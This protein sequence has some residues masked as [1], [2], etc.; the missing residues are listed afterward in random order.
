MLANDE[1]GAPFERDAMPRENKVGTD[2]IVVGA[3]ERLVFGDTPLQFGIRGGRCGGG[4]GG[5]TSRRQEGVLLDD[6]IC[7]ATEPLG[8]V[9][10]CICGWIADMHILLVKFGTPYAIPYRGPFGRST[11]S[12]GL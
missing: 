6:G 7:E 8:I 5:G 1:N 12:A 2:V 10:V 4:G 11:S 9:P 3:F